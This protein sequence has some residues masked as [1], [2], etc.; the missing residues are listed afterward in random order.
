MNDDQARNRFLVIGL[1]RMAGVAMVL[2]GILIVEGIISAPKFVGYI[3]GIIGLA[4]VF[5][6]PRYLARKW[7]TPRTP[8]G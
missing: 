7:R 6:M 1:M 8:R 4:D 2:V 5:I 3:I